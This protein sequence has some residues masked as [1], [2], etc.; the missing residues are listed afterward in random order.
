MILALIFFALAVLPLKIFGTMA[1]LGVLACAMGGIMDY[2]EV[3]QFG[4]IITVIG[5]VVFVLFLIWGH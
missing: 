2:Q 4:L 1:I 5:T 3:T